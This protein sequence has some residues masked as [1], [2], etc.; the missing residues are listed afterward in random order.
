MKKR[1]ETKG[2]LLY[3]GVVLR[4]GNILINQDPAKPRLQTR[5]RSRTV[6]KTDLKVTK[7]NVKR[8]WNVL[9]DD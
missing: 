5:C 1:P 4:G 7:K 6:C 9:I 3:P 8:V 2:T